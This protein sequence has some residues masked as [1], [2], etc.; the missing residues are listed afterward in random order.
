[1][2]ILLV[3]FFHPELVRGGSQQVCY[4]LFQGL[5]ERQD[6]DV[7]LLASIDD[8]YPSLFKVGASVTGFDG[9]PGEYLF[10]TREYD[11]R[12]HHNSDPRL[13]AAFAEFLRTVAPDVVH[14]HHYMGYGV[15]YLSLARAVLPKARIV[16]TFHEFISICAADGQ[17]VRKLD[18][19][20]C[21]RASPV[22]CHQCFPDLPP[23]QFFMREKWIK[24]HL[25]AVDIFATPSKFM[26]KH[27]ADWGIDPARIVCVPNA[28][29]N[30]NAERIADDRRERRNRFGFFG[31]LVE[32]KGVQVLL[33][34]VALLRAD[35][36]T[37]FSVEINGDNLR[38][39]PQALRQ[40]IEDCRA[41]EA[42]LPAGER[43]VTFNGA[44][45]TDQLAARMARVDW[46]IVPS[47]W[48]EIFGLVI[49]EAWMF[50][51]PVIASDVGGPAERI[52]HEV[53][54]LKFRMGDARSLAQTIRR[55]CE[56]QDLW[57]RL[58]AGIDEP[59]PLQNM[60]DGYIKL[61]SPTVA[62]RAA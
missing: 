6:V 13:A 57:E 29:R 60:V 31:Q 23:E 61:Y 55:A 21:S 49:S 43:I 51:R 48:W 44:Y 56:E 4:E 5:K 15:D 17:M 1:M 58:V 53:D 7:T 9:R 8:T 45:H 19:S 22:R 52:R 30:Y 25:E 34:A 42:E 16:F 11:Y 35:E 54:G 3:S 37:D 50:G 26:M 38:Y 36:F 59:T 32:N 40:E 27:Y 14:F 46:C 28:Q 39:A 18:G 10:L 41:A 2:K 24:K 62:E 20:L 47:I 12:W 33:K